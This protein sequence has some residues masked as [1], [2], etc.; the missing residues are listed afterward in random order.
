MTDVTQDR[1][2][3]TTQVAAMLGVSPATVVEY[4]EKGQL[5]FFRL[6]SGHRRFHRTDVEALRT[7][8]EPKRA[9]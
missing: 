6:P 1:P 5:S 8:A 3:T 7:A 9:S 4:A 2:M